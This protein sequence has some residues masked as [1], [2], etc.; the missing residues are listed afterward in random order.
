[1]SHETSELEQERE[2]VIEILAGHYAEDRL[3]LDEYE[4]R[5]ERAEDA[6]TEQALR[7]LIVDLEPEEP[8]EEESGGSGGGG[9]LVPSPGQDLASKKGRIATSG[10]RSSASSFGRGGPPRPPDRA[11]AR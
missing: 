4:R 5:V 1:M 10:A 9:P 8:E 7:Q 3:E 11:L 6:T 2:L